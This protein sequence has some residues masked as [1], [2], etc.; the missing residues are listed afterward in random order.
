MILDLRSTKEIDQIHGK[1]AIIG[2]G[3]AGITLARE[4]G[5]QF[6]DVVVLES[7]GFDFEQETQALYDGPIIG[8]ETTELEFSRLR[9]FGGST[10]H[11]QGFCASLDAVDFERLPDRP[12]SGWPFKLEDL[13]PFYERAYQYCELGI[14]R[15]GSALLAEAEPTSRQIIDTPLFQL[16]EFRHSPPTL[17]GSR[18]RSELASSDRIKVYL[19]A[20]VTDIVVSPN[21]QVVTALDVRTLTGRELRVT[22]DIFIL[23]CGGIE[24]ARMLL[25]CS[26]YF[27]S[28][29]GNEYDLVGRFFMDHLNTFGGTI[30]PRDSNFNLAPFLL[31]GGRDGDVPISLVFKN[32]AQAIRQEKRSACSVF[33]DPQYEIFEQISKVESSPT[34][35]A[36]RDLIR[37]AKHGRIPEKIEERGCAVLDDPQSIVT[38]LYYRWAKRLGN[39]GALK[40][41]TVRMTG[42]QLPNPFSRVVLTEKLD[43]L[44]MRK[45]GLDWRIADDD[46]ESLYETAMTFARSVGATGFGRM[47]V[48]TRGEVNPRTGCH[49]M[50]TTRMHDDRRQGVVERNCRVHGIENLFIA[51]SSV[52]PTTG[53]V[54]PTLTIV[55]LAIRLADYLK[56]EAKNI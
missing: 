30:V 18:F 22:A 12:F 35:E 21:G 4:L 17:F 52:F 3:A 16:A 50:G 45:V 28:G 42:E 38:A 2:A 34:F 9:F 49:H 32:S 55:A 11:W 26:G 44:G 48:P 43:T 37:D 46:Y 25:N 54:N 53:R 29:I 47:R 56:L 15:N 39:R 23:C 40:T 5:D 14:Y 31:H 19:H 10:N 41:V 8:H 7:G 1:I 51:G 6:R 20:N 24:N 27:P 36:V 13:V 33:L